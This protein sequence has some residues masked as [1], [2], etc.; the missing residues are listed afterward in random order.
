[1]K[2]ERNIISE[3]HMIQYIPGDIFRASFKFCMRDKLRGVKGMKRFSVHL[4]VHTPIQ[5]VF[6]NN[7]ENVGPLS[8]MKPCTRRGPTIGK[9][10]REL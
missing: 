6:L 9:N 7:F 1:L 3:R 2:A 5:I 4:N 10:I 8:K